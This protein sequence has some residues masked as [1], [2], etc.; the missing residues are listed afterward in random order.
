MSLPSIPVVAR[1]KGINLDVLIG[2]VEQKLILVEAMRRDLKPALDLLHTKAHEA[3]KSPDGRAHWQ[4][5]PA[6]P[7][8]KML[9]R[10]HAGGVLKA[11]AEEEFCHRQPLHFFNCCKGVVGKAPEDP[12]L[13]Q[14][15]CQAGPIAFADC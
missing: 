4:E 12:M 11:L 8:G 2:P 3:E 15:Q 1:E 9:T 10:I 5:D 7:I 13:I 6:S 14:I